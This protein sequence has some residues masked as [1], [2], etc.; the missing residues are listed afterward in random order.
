M[1]QQ[2]IEETRNLKKISIRNLVNVGMAGWMTWCGY[3]PHYGFL[4]LS[5]QDFLCAVRISQLSREEQVSDF[6]H[7]MSNPM[8]FVLL[9]ITKLDNTRICRHL[10]GIG[11]NRL[12]NLNLYKIFV[13]P[14]L[15][16]SDS[17]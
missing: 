15:K 13:I 4:H 10:H 6:K 1:T 7:I 9:C 8:S 12:N 17:R 14:R 3:D 2:K 5:V 16:L 11:K